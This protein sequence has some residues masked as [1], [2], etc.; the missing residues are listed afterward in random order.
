MHHAIIICILLILTV[1]SVREHSHT[2]EQ[3]PNG[4]IRAGIVD[5]AY[6]H[7]HTHTLEDTQWLQTQ[8]HWTH[9][10]T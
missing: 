2:Q 5:T 8:S 4:I 1:C 3:Y 6:T 9:S 10:A 7:T